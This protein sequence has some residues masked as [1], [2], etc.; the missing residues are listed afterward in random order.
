MILNP[1]DDDGCESVK[2][3][4]EHSSSMSET[5]LRGTK[6]MS[7]DANCEKSDKCS[8]KLSPGSS[9]TSEK[10]MRSSTGMEVNGTESDPSPPTLNV[11]SDFVFSGDIS[12]VPVP[13]PL[14]IDGSII[15]P[16]STSENRS[17]PGECN[18]A[19]SDALPLL[20]NGF[21]SDFAKTDDD[22]PAPM[23]IDASILIPQ[24][25]SQNRSFPGE[26]KGT[27]SDALP[28]TLQTLGSDFVNNDDNSPVPLTI[29]ASIITRKTASKNRSVPREGVE[30]RRSPRVSSTTLSVGSQVTKTKSRSTK[31]H[32]SGHNM[33][34]QLSSETRSTS[35]KKQRKLKTESFFVGDPVPEDEAQEKW[36]WRYKLKGQT[37]KGQSSIVNIGGDDEVHID[38]LCHYIQASVDGCIFNLGDCA[39]IKG[40]GKQK[41]V[42]RI[43]EFFKTSD[44]KNYF[45]VQWFFRAEDTV[46]KEAAAILDKKRL[47]AS[48]LM[49]DNL[50]DCILSKVKIIEKAPGLTSIHPSD[51][52]CDMEYSVKYSTFRS[53]LTA[54]DNSVARCGLTLTTP[55]CLDANNMGISTTPLDVVKSDMHKAELALLDLYAGCG[56]MSTGLCLGAKLSGVKLVTKWAI[57]YQKSACDSLKQ[58][59]PETQVRHITAEDFLQLL[60]EWEKLCKKYVFND[61]DIKTKSDDDKKSKINESSVEDDEVAPGE[62]EV[63]SLVDICYGDPSSTGQDGLKFKVRWKGYGPTDDTWELIE[64]LSDCQDHIQDFVRHGYESKILP[65][66]GDVDVIC[67]GP[68]CQ[69][70]SGYNRFRNTDNPLTDERNQ[71]IVVFFDIVKFLK[72]KYVLMENVADILRFDKGSLGRYALSRL[73]H[74]N[75][76]ARLGLMAAGSYGLPQ[77]RLRVF[78]WGAL[79]TQRLPQFPLPTHE[80]IV[81]YFPPAEFEQHTVAY[82]EGQPRELQEAIVL[83]DAISDLPPVTSHEEREEIPYEMPPQ[84][85]FQK[86]IRLTKDE[87]NGYD[88]KGD[89]DCKSSVLTDHR[90]YK[91]SEDDFHRVCYVPHRKGA[92]F[93]DFPGI[94]VSSD[95]VVRLNKKVEQVLLPSG[96]PLIPDYVF[97]F[98]KGRSRRPFARLWWD[99]NVPTVLTIPNLHSQKALHPEQDRVLTVRECARLQGFPDHY[100]FCGNVKERY[101]QVGNAVAVSVSKTLG[102][103]LGMAFK[104]LSGDEAL[105]TLPPGFAFQV[106]PP[107]LEEFSSQL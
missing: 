43:V 10:R 61:H 55:S 101:C 48:T 88:S 91:L 95:N 1:V 89:T 103:A 87:F 2:G 57:D 14:T 105:M 30:L 23:T 98:E 67:G 59:H 53:L 81:R 71:Q 52:Y 3:L 77:F 31:L 12:P 84:T 41:H 97:T 47:F 75:Y 63:S 28:L 26:S 69:G 35:N 76:Q 37:H 96:K 107:P 50:L 42:G 22:S 17:V 102:Y 49:N 73:I 64:G 40:E 82:D 90:T 25:A 66:P 6:R 58:N 70:I 38:V 8:P 78:I 45:R 39:H 19:E 33:A 34:L 15:T 29:D 104:K 72:P 16:N 99:E 9:S 21:G 44:D 24:S 36:G 51:Y 54:K 83:R 32:V 46:M 92:S 7:P 11:S 100:R 62:Y 18:G 20:S 56:G 74:M 4:T 93:R 27:E 68:P 60:K 5:V 13:V 85:E 65:L 80:V 79:P 106:P 86:Y 94:I